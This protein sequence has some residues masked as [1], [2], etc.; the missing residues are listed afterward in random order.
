MASVLMAGVLM[1]IGEYKRPA[2][3]EV[4][5]A[6]GERRILPGSPPRWRAYTD[7]PAGQ[8]PSVTGE[9]GNWVLA[10]EHAIVRS[11]REARFVLV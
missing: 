11:A 5:R 6:R 1:D 4:H 9:D 8:Q 3:R 7:V 2:E 10:M